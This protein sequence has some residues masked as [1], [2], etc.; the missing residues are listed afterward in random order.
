M[1]N[2]FTILV[3]FVSGILFNVFWGYILG[4]GYG[5]MAVRKAML[6][7]LLIM[8]KNIQSIYEIQQ[9]KYMSYEMLDRDEKY[10]EFQ[11]QIDKNEMNSL[12]NT[13]I[14]NYINSV[15]PKYND[16]VKFNDWDSAMLFLNDELKK[17]RS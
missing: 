8:V 6:D 12:K 15:P 16:M 3:A 2:A 7:C 14:R 5:A 9:L 10:V 11:K 1:E 13:L 17:E 4:L